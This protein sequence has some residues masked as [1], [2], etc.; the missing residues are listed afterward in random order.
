MTAKAASLPIVGVPVVSQRTAV[1]NVPT[2][3]TVQVQI[4]GGT[5]I[6]GSATLLQL[7]P[8]G[9]TNIL[10][11]LH[12]DGINGDFLPN[13]GELTLVVPLNAA[14]P[15]QVQLQVIAA[16]KGVRQKIK[17]SVVTLFFQPANAA[18]LS[19]HSLSAAL[20]A[21]NLSG[22]L[23]WFLPSQSNSDVLHGLSPT[24][25]AALAKDF[26]GATLI[27]S[28]PDFRTYQTTFL[29]VNGSTTPVTFDMVPNSQGQWVISNW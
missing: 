7:N 23:Q 27:S 13:D 20:K 17:S 14:T 5:L 29:E 19:I 10:G 21:G 11:V 12:D 2:Q 4:E 18:D 24:G 6:P 26:S 9:S 16:F 25:M 3:I 15:S 28:K 1:V 22:S 8:N